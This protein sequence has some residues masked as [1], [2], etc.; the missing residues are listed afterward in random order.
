MRMKGKPNTGISARSQSMGSRS[1]ISR[2]QPAGSQQCDVGC[3]SQ[4]GW[5]EQETETWDLKKTQRDTD[6]LKT[7]WERPQVWIK[8]KKKSHKG[9][10]FK[11]A[12]HLILELQKR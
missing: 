9:S 12:T 4:K 10:T 11:E 7:S 2:S 3:E 6:D 1:S 5:A 8:K